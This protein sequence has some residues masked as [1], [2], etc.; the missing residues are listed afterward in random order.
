MEKLKEFVNG[1]GLLLGALAIAV[2][3]IEVRVSYCGIPVLPIT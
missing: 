1:V 2:G 3:I